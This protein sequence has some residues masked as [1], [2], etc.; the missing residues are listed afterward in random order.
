M[1]KRR[2]MSQTPLFDSPIWQALQRDWQALQILSENPVLFDSWDL[3]RV[4]L[5]RQ[6]TPLQRL[7]LQQQLTPE[8]QQIIGELVQLR[9]EQALSAQ[10]Q[11]HGH[12]LYQVESQAHRGP[13]SR[14]QALSDLERAMLAQQQ[15]QQLSQTPRS[16]R[17][18]VLHDQN[19]EL[20]ERFA[21]RQSRE[22]RASQW[23]AALK[24]LVLLSWNEEL[25]PQALDALRLALS[26]LSQA[27]KV[28][29][30][31]L[32]ALKSSRQLQVQCAAIRLLAQAQPL[33]WEDL[34]RLLKSPHTP[35]R[36]LQEIMSLPPPY[37]EGLSAALIHLLTRAQAD[38]TGEQ[39]SFGQL[40][41]QALQLLP[42]AASLEERP[43]VLQL[44]QQARDWHVKTR[45]VAIQVLAEFDYQVGFEETVA[46]L[47]QAAREDDMPLLELATETLVK[48]KNPDARPFL[49]AVLNGQY[50]QETAYER[51]GQA[52]NAEIQSQYPFLKNALERLGQRVIEDPL[53]GQWRVQG[54]F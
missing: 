27:S 42:R 38:L 54:A 51:Y 32:R 16:I 53:T 1:L 12:H 25:N 22:T 7:V 23:Q 10:K 3:L 39:I 33:P 6:V 34:L 11:Q 19:F 24:W 29:S 46:L 26:E 40:R 41:R 35:S 45:L 28:P 43:E 31:A 8:D 21:R 36:V 52:F 17:Q 15:E 50:R 44:F 14:Y 9:F 48:L 49:L 37:P 30:L 13:F 47:Q 5:D 2:L 18:A 4:Y 20:M